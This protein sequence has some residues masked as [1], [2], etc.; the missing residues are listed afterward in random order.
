MLIGILVNGEFKC[1]GT[2]SHLKSTYG[3][4][5]KISVV[6]RN[7]NERVYEEALAEAFPG[8][9]REDENS[10]IYATYRADRG[11]LIGCSD[12]REGA[13]GQLTV[14]TA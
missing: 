9:I 7:S 3:T 12:L 13:L 8:T 2:L 11:L 10:E 4:G 1:I 5:Y 14:H 6:K